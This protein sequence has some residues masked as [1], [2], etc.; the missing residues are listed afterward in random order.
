MWMK[1]QYLIMYSFHELC[2]MCVDT[3]TV[4]LCSRVNA[5]TEIEKQGCDYEVDG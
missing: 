5:R 4:R 3:C 1:R 2:V